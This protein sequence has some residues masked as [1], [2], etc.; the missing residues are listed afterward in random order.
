[1]TG[2]NDSLRDKGVHVGGEKY[3]LLQSDDQQIQAKKGNTGLSVAKANTCC[4]IGVYH[5]GITAGNCRNAV[6]KMRGYLSDQ[7]F[8][9]TFTTYV[10]HNNIS[11]LSYV[12]QDVH[13]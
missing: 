12:K 1:M 9:V 4:V 8:Q 6:E 10:V 7:N 13:I 5:D 3:F 11:S 2:T